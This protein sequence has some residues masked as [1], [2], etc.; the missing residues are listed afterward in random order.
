MV[1]NEL[2][3][4]ETKQ[5]YKKICDARLQPYHVEYDRKSSD[6]YYELDGKK[7]RLVFDGAGDWFCDII[8][9]GDY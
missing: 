9:Q 3:A 7:Y 2:N 4:E 8:Y 1:E 6:H 5:I